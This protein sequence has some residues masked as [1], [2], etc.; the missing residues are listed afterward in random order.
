MAAAA[1][2]GGPGVSTSEMVPSRYSHTCSSTDCRCDLLSIYILDVGLGGTAARR[3]I[4]LERAG[5]HDGCD[6]AAP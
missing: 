6:G 4:E 3:K 5:G 2:I 1:A